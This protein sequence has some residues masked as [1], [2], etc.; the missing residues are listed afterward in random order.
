MHGAGRKT[1]ILDLL[2][3]TARRRPDSCAL[4][5]KDHEISYSDLEQSIRSTATALARRGVEAGDHVGVCLL[6]QPEYLISI[7]AVWHL[8]ATAV[9]MNYRAPA[10]EKQRLVEQL[11]IDVVVERKSFGTDTP[12]PYLVWEPEWT[13]RY[14]SSPDRHERPDDPQR[15]A[16]ISPTSGTTGLPQGIV[17]TEGEVVARYFYARRSQRSGMHQRLLSSF[18]LAFKGSLSP[19]LNTLLD[20]GT[21]ILFP[22]L[23]TAEEWINGCRRYRAEA[24]F[25]VPP[26]VRDLVKMFGSRDRMFS[27]FKQLVSGGGSLTPEEKIHA[28]DV[29]GPAFHEIYACT[30]G[31][32]V[33]M[34]S[35][36]EIRRHADS[37]GRALTDATVQIV[38]DA[39]R[40]LPAGQRGL[41][42]FK[43][44][45]MSTRIYGRTA[46]EP[47]TSGSDAII[48][49]WAYP[50]EI[51]YVDEERY[52][53]LCGRSSDVIVRGGSNIHPEE[54]EVVLSA[55][56]AVREC[57]VVAVESDILGQ[58]IAAF[59]VAEDSVTEKSLRSFC[60]HQLAPGKRPA[61]YVFVE[62]LP[63]NSA[64]K[65]LRRKLEPL[66][67]HSSS[68]G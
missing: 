35:G 48:D 15:V 33:S 4:V 53:H 25:V 65:V 34:L 27:G 60:L 23:F 24:A 38:D 19:C 2:G 11:D 20:G 3:G 57:A 9:P 41:L 64:G 32:V 5:F 54:I 17:Q 50:G 22:T 8:G 58:D 67:V 68:E 61:I 36:E 12:Y 56:P 66:K 1:D 30:L 13:E 43:A 10:G 16:F 44:P 51:A 37:V 29:V 62:E 47:V 26:L 52:I 49:G 59:V 55:H 28:L 63:R 39:N 45:G 40:P 31:G 21:V 14:R 18:P 46:G 6:D 42:R 7:L